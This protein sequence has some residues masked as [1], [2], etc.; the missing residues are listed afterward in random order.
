VPVRLL[1]QGEVAAARGQLL[2]I[3]GGAVNEETRARLGLPEAGGAL[4]VARVVGSPAD[5][6]GI[7]LDAVIVAVNGERVTSPTELSRLI[8]AAGPGREVEITYFSRGER[9]TAAVTLGGPAGPSAGPPAAPPAEERP[10]PQRPQPL[11]GDPAA[12]Q[13]PQQQIQQLERRIRELEQRVQE[14]ERALRALEPESLLR[15]AQ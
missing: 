15:K 2:G 5:K 1:N 3:R 4:V 8:A 6:A 13:T 11:G 9:H 10:L 14:L 7:P 12:P